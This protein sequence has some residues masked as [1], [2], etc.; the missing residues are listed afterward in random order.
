M[1]DITENTWNEGEK[2]QS[3]LLKSLLLR[4]EHLLGHGNRKKDVQNAENVILSY[5]M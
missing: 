1:P 3:S 2:K 5:S 4:R